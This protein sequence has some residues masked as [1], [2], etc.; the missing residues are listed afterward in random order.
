M[1]ET[2]DLLREAE[3]LAAAYGAGVLRLDE[4][5]RAGA[6]LKEPCAEAL[7]AV[8]TL[9]GIAGFAGMPSV[10]RVAGVTEGVLAAVREGRIELGDALFGL[11]LAAEAL[12]ALGLRSTHQADESARVEAWCDAVAAVVAVSGVTPS[13]PVAAALDRVDPTL[14]AMLST[15][16]EADLLSALQRGLRVFVWE[17]GYELTE[18]ELHLEQAQTRA[19]EVAEWLALLPGRGDDKEGELSLAALL[20][21]ELDVHELAQ[22]L[23]C[24]A[25]Q[26][27][28]AEAVQPRATATSP[29]SRAPM[30]VEPASPVVRVD[31]NVLDTMLSE[32]AV[33]ARDG[34]NV[35]AR[36][37]HISRLREAVVGA[38]GVEMAQ[39]Y[40]RLA[41]ATRQA[42]LELGKSVRLTTTGGELQLDKR[43]ADS[44]FEP[45]LHVVRNALDHGIESPDVRRIKGKP[46]TGR[47]LLG[48]Y[49]RSGGVVVEVEDDGAGVDVAELR[50]R[51][52]A[53]GVVSA[54]A[55]AKASDEQCLAWVFLPGFSTR[56]T[57]TDVSG[58]GVG[59]DAVRASVRAVGG[60]VELRS[61]AGVGTK[62]S[63]FL[64]RLAAVMK[65]MHLQLGE[66]R[67]DIPLSRVKEL[68]MLSAYESRV[69]AGERL[70]RKD[71]ESFFAVALARLL[72][73]VDDLHQGTPLVARLHGDSKAGGLLIY[74]P[75][76]TGEVVLHP[77]G[78]AFEHVR[79]YLG[80]SEHAD[81]QLGLVVDDVAL[82]RR[83]FEPVTRRPSNAP[84]SQKEDPGASLMLRVGSDVYALPLHWVRD[85][86]REFAWISPPDA[87]AGV[88]G[89]S[90]TRGV[91]V[92]VLDPAHIAGGAPANSKP[93]LLVYL[94]HELEGIAI[95]CD[96]AD[97]EAPPGAPEQART[98]QVYSYAEARSFLGRS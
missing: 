67:V 98:L 55:A 51:A 93:K 49:A 7:R 30:G 24:P 46:E 72:G 71:D 56:S 77:M 10:G 17:R 48:A 78:R 11:L 84:I 5:V 4:A 60:Q 57:V 20:A 25:S 47:L 23:D 73:R 91:V 83:E 38:R 59:L 65:V 90:L 8:H 15:A 9:K 75:V 37:M 35:A 58:R 3:E 1:T 21:T 64:P 34:A 76:S 22:K 33:L 16:E 62:L 63:L 18:L 28:A 74:P 29:I 82:L 50:A 87:P 68:L 6:P 40:D 69:V 88:R 92:T 41:R 96:S 89:V 79:G 43:L 12:L 39:L 45:L 44:V 32:L 66:L 42:S 36:H 19:K 61:V 26:L 54:E 14:R 86:A 52:I 80:V 31:I 81:G 2:T 94:A 70:L 53:E 95:A 85:V 27:R 13:P 97:L